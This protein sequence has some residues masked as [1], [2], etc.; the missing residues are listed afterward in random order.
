MAGMKTATTADGRTVAWKTYGASNQATPVVINIH[1]SG[2]E[3]GFE[4]T[5]YAKACQDLGVKGLAISLPGCGYSD[6]KPGRIVKDWPLEDLAVVL[7]AEKIDR[8]HITGHSQGTPHA[9]ATAMAYPERCIGLGLNAPLV[10]TALVE[11]L[12]LGKTIGTG[13]T[14]NSTALKSFWMGWYF[15]V[16]CLVLEVFPPSLIARFITKGLPRVQADKELQSR[17]HASMK[18]SVIRGA[19]GGV[20]ETA[21]DTCFEWGIDITKLQHRNVCVWHADDDTAIPAFQGKWLAQQL[22]ADYRHEAEGYGHMTYT[23]GRYRTAESSMIK[24]LIDGIDE[25]FVT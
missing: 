19:C 16:M 7:E 5:V 10:P 18:R 20:W 24:K 4:E 15:G 21:Q 9:M 17:F 1:G 23:V 22:N 11:E 2:L 14:P 12:N 6:Q 8:F 25:K 3:A 13:F